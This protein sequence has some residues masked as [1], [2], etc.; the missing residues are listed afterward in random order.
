MAP[1]G[2]GVRE[3][4]KAVIDKEPRRIGIHLLEVDQLL[5]AKSEVCR[6][7]EDLE[8][9][10]FVEIATLHEKVHHS[11]RRRVVE[12][13]KDNLVDGPHFHEEP[14]VVTGVCCVHRDRHRAARPVGEQC[15]DFKR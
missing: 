13:L 12:I 11:K 3:S 14:E 1:V 6:H 8:E 5:L 15:C 7:K 10:G 2:R 9:I 4:H